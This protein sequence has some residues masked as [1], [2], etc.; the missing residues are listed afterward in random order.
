MPICPKIL[1]SHITF[2]RAYNM[3]KYVK[4][5]LIRFWPVWITPRHHFPKMLVSGRRLLIDDDEFGALCD[6]E[7][8]G[9]W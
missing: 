9:V 8:D 6:T 1:E 3:Q 5:K 4:R 2:M 7:K